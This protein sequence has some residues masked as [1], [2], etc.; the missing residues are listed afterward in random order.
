MEFT[1][2]RFLPQL[3]GVIELEHVHRYLYSMPFVEG[4]DV[5]DIACG[6]GYGSAL[7]ARK[8]KTVAG[9]DID[10][11]SISKAKK[12]YSSQFRLTFSIGSLLSIPVPDASID[13][14]T[15][16]E[17]I[18]HVTDHDQV[19]NEFKRILKAD[20]LLLLSTPNRFVYSDLTG[21]KNPFHPRELYQNEFENLLSRFF[22]N[23]KTVGQR[24]ALSSIITGDE[25]GSLPL[26]WFFKNDETDNSFVSQSMYF[27]SIASD[28]QLP[29]LTSSIYEG[30]SS[31]DQI[32]AQRTPLA[33]K[34]EAIRYLILTTPALR[35][36]ILPIYKIAKNFLVRR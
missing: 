24:V 23:H 14:I 11:E 18:E 3:S 13:V 33:S 32:L 17:S 30:Q 27:F 15:C 19:M 31:L 6:E 20:G 4:K 9:I 22:L 10:D 12:N 26:N 34:R 1:G 16:F 2:E 21:Y 8:A 28:G 29:N 5:L 25:N 35:A 36:T 7:L